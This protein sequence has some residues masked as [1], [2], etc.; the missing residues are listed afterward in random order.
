MFF[1]S[2]V[3][4][5]VYAPVC[6]FDGGSCHYL[7]RSRSDADFRSYRCGLWGGGADARSHAR[8]LARLALLSFVSLDRTARSD[9]SPCGQGRVFL[10][11]FPVIDWSSSIDSGRIFM[12]EVINV[13]TALGL[14]PILFFAVVL[15]FV[16]FVVR[17]IFFLFLVGRC[18]FGG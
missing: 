15:A 11:G 5:G 9:A 18:V 16:F 17:A 12:T 6:R 1:P 7:L 2:L 14:L 10:R 13:L 4:G 3:P 8:A